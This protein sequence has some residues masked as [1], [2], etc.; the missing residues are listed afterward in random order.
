MLYII[1]NCDTQKAIGTRKTIK[2]AYNFCKRLEYLGLSN[3][4]IHEFDDDY[5]KCPSVNVDEFVFSYEHDKIKDFST[6]NDK[7]REVKDLDVQQ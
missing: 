1:R 6:L 3:F 2:S 4:S 7:I 5:D